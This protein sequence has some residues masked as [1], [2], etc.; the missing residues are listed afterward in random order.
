MEIGEQLARFAWYVR[1]G[2]IHRTGNMPRFERLHRHHVNDHQRTI[3]QSPA[4]LGTRND[5]ATG[6]FLDN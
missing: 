2:K 4:K 5:Q 3:R 1:D 6:A